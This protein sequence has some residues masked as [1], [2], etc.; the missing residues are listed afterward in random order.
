LANAEP[1][2]VPLA[3]GGHR[4]RPIPAR[5]GRQHGVLLGDPKTTHIS[6]LQGGFR[7]SQKKQVLSGFRL[8]VFTADNRWFL[9]GDH[10]LHW[11]SQNTCGLGADTLKADAENAKSTSIWD[12]GSVLGF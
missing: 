12:T 10:R 6:T 4:R 3:S 7:A 1:P 5:S 8:S 11:T 2:D 9:Q